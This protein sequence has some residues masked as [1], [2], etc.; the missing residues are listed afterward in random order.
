MP[1]T[2]KTVCGRLLA[3]LAVTASIYMPASAAPGSRGMMMNSVRQIMDQARGRL[4]AG[5]TTSARRLAEAFSPR[6]GVRLYLNF[7]S[8]GDAS[9]ADCYAAA[10]HAV[11]AWSREVPS[12]SIRIVRDPSAA[13]WIVNFDPSVRLGSTEVAGETSWNPDLTGGHIQVRTVYGRPI[14]A[15]YMAHELTHELG[16]VLG[17]EDSPRLGDVM[18]PLDFRRPAAELT[19][20]EAAPARELQAEAHAI[21]EQA[22]STL[23]CAS[24]P[25]ETQPVQD[26]L[27]RELPNAPR[28]PRFSLGTENACAQIE[29]SQVWQASEPSIVAFRLE[30][31]KARFV[32]A[33]HPAAPHHAKVKRHARH[34]RAWRHW[35]RHWRRAHRK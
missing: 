17:L 35:R 21:C 27:I 12:I 10:R 22:D 7:C 30:A 33:K 20:D 6:D 4:A 31:P 25:V 28:P 32:P 1:S 19:D 15:E 24:K 11:E 18:G 26:T 13:N 8:N 29:L 23:T 9:E 2:P 14:P 5:D 16:H 34:R 3:G